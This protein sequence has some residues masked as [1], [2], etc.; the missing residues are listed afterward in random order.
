MVSVKRR[1]EVC[2]S[3]KADLPELKLSA[4]QSNEK[5]IFFEYINLGAI[6]IKITMRFE[7]KALELGTVRQGL[8]IAN[9]L[10]IVFTT[11]ATISDSPLTFKELIIVNTYTT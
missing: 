8:G 11:V 10:Q 6:K 1:D 3:L 2:E 5:K 9:V 4:S 7:K